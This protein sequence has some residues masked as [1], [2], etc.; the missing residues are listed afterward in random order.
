MERSEA[1]KVRS[2]MA[3]EHPDRATH[4][5]VLSERDDEWTVAKVALPP[6]LAGDAGPRVGDQPEPLRSRDGDR[7]RGRL[8]GR[9][10]GG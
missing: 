3:A 7:P 5:F 9:A 1:E 2:R 6:G 8:P 4:S 10:G